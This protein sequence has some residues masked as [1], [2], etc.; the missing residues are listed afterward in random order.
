MNRR[1]KELVWEKL[2]ESMV[3]T[4]ADL[5]EGALRRRAE[6]QAGLMREP[7]GEEPLRSRSV[8]P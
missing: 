2:H 3:S 5:E 6:P 7:G 4:A 1:E 8:T